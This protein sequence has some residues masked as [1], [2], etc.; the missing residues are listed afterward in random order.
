LSRCAWR[1]GR[2]AEC[3]GFE[4]RLTSNGHGGS[5]PSLS[6]ALSDPNVGPCGWVRTRLCQGVG[7]EVLYFSQHSTQWFGLRSPDGQ[8]EKGCDI[9]PV[10]PARTFSVGAVEQRVV[11]QPRRVR[12]QLAR[13]ENRLI[14]LWD[15][16]RN[17][18][19]ALRH[20]A[21]ANSQKHK[22]TC[23]TKTVG[24]ALQD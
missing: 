9:N 14:N 7:V 5:N 22:K 15:V 2:A 8:F 23:T 13:A 16:I 12:R 17:V 3:A 4:N 10:F 24:S 18:Q 11:P 6:V 19:R 21:P 20:V 1:V